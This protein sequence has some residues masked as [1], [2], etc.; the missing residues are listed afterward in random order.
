ME[1]VLTVPVTTDRD[2]V[3][4]RADAPV[5]LVL[6]G[7]YECPYSGKAH[8]IVHEVQARMAGRLRFVFRNFP[9]TTL[10]PHAEHAAEAAE[11]AAAQGKFW[12]MHDHLY[13][14]QKRLR[15]RDLHAYADQLG[16]DVERFDKDLAE[17]A[18]LP[19]INDDLRSGVR[20]GVEGTPTF[21]VNGV[22]HDDSYDAEAL[23]EALQRAAVEAPGAR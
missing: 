15:D 1:A 7:D 4:G 10:H 3:K 17:H 13:E 5:T 6:Y 11:A 21:F 12:E 22:R 23:L 8:P 20:S 2:H 18:H 9:L 16:L 19:R 14:N